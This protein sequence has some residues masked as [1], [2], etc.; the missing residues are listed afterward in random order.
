RLFAVRGRRTRLPGLQP[1]RGRR[2]ES[3]VNLSRRKRFCG[4]IRH[5]SLLLRRLRNQG[6]STMPSAIDSVLWPRG[7]CHCCVPSTIFWRFF[8]GE[9]VREFAPR[10]LHPGD[11]VAVAGRGLV[12]L[13]AASAL[14]AR[15]GLTPASGDGVW[16]A[17]VPRRAC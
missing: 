2:D 17:S 8:A 13:S 3:W 6:T 16:E 4:G 7:G 11:G 1:E 14:T 12:A 5:E 15:P 10:A 9:S